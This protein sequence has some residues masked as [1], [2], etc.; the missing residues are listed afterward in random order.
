[1]TH[2]GECLRCGRGAVTRPRA[3][4]ADHVITSSPFLND[5]CMQMNENRACT[6][7]SS[8][9]DTDRFLPVNRFT[10]DVTPTI[11]WTGTFSTRVYLDLLRPVFQELAKRRAFKLR[12]IG[13]FDTLPPE[14]REWFRAR[15]LVAPYLRRRDSF[16]PAQPAPIRQRAR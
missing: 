7:I 15:N 6:Y 10:N 9:V 12:V 1:M 2:R 3:D 8:S 5:T 13:N 4:Y 16:E 14:R 11:G